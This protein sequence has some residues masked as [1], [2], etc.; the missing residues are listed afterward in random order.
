MIKDPIVEE[1]HNIREALLAQYGGLDGYMR[2]LEELRVEFKDR[3]V[4]R[5]PRRPVEN[6]KA[7]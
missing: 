6:R 3:I 7:S 1:I 4:H 5:Q 2:H